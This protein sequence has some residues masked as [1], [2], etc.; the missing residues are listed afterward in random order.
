MVKELFQSNSPKDSMHRKLNHHVHCMQY[1]IYNYILKHYAK[2]I[3]WGF[4]CLK[5][6]RLNLHTL[7]LIIGYGVHTPLHWKPIENHIVHLCSTS[8]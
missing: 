1:N 7:Y 3:L 4:V 2:G 8:T 6:N 5:F